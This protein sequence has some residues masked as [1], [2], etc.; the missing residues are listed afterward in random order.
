MI[1]NRS[2]WNS[3]GCRMWS[4]LVQIL[5]L[6]E[7]SWSHTQLAAYLFIYLLFIR[8]QWYN[9]VNDED[10]KC[11][12]INKI[13]QLHKACDGKLS[14]RHITLN[15]DVTL[16]KAHCVVTYEMIS[17]SDIFASETMNRAQKRH[18]VAKTNSF[19]KLVKVITLSEVI[20]LMWRFTNRE[21]V[22]PDVKSW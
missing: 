1:V 19:I 11:T 8:R 22:Q 15:A 12:C 4:N 2:A 16:V 14:K 17:E 13:A 18:F 3:I 10:N 7:Y 20:L 6:I 5:P 21:S 9:H